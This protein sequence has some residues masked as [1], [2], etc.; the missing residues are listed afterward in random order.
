[1][2]FLESAYISWWTPSLPLTRSV[3][4]M[5]SPAAYIDSPLEAT[6][7]A[8]LSPS[9]RPLLLKMCI[10]KVESAGASPAA[11]GVFVRAVGTQGFVRA[12][13]GPR[14]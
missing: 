7:P 11:A 9:G 1:M 2:I 10:T 5:G 8:D 14:S 12:Q 6:V 4:T 13:R 3:S